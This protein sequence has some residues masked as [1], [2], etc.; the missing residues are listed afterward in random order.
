MR[1]VQCSKKKI[2]VVVRT[3][4]LGWTIFKLEVTVIFVWEGDT[5]IFTIRC[6]FVYGEPGKGE[7][8][9]RRPRHF[10]GS[11][12]AGRQAGEGRTNYR[13]IRPLSFN[14]FRPKLKNVDC[15]RCRQVG[16][17]ARNCPLHG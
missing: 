9:G 3:L 10:R 11:V 14:T 1:V 13:P 7:V 5:Y 2:N 4:Y 12:G 16:Q 6:K 15:F 17:I 8:S